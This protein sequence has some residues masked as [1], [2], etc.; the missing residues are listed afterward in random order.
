MTPSLMCLPDFSSTNTNSFL[1]YLCGF[2]F[3]VVCST[4]V[5]GAVGQ[6]LAHYDVVSQTLAHD[7]V[8]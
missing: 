7:L 6:T 2:S 3:A 8:L 1:H 4:D 5:T